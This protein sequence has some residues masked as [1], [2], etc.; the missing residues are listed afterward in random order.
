[1]VTPD[2]VFPS[3]YTADRYGESSQPSAL[4]WDQIEPTDY[5]P[6]AD[7]SQIIQELDG[8]HQARMEASPEYQ[9]LLEDIALMQER[10][11]EVT[12]SLAEDKLQ[13]ERDLNQQKNRAR[14][15]EG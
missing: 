8:R 5:S 12:V 1:G 4:P 3:T 15:N 13:E 9:F 11:N 2:L 6:V 10:E 7:L 14:V